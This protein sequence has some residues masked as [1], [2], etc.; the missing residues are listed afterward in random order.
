MTSTG[1][2]MSPP[3]ALTSSRHISMAACSILP[4]GAPAPVSARLM[5]TL[6]GLPLC[7]AA[8]SSPSKLTSAA[9]A[10]DRN[11]FRRPF[12]IPLPRHL[13]W[14]AFARGLFLP[15]IPVRIDQLAGLPLRRPDHRQRLAGAELLD[16]VRLG[17][18]HLR[19]DRARLGPFAVLG[20][21]EIA[22]HG[23]EARL[24]QVC[25]ELVVIEALGFGHGL[26]QRLARRVSER[27]PG[28]AQRVDAGGRGLGVVALQE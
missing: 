24:V 19:P 28:K 4:A 12:I 5:P 13:F 9:A 16:V 18:L 10:S 21:G 11:A 23:L 20:E 22:G 7:A 8:P 14:R 25:G 1:R 27:S 2:P 3:L 26:R 6:I 17:V 15:R